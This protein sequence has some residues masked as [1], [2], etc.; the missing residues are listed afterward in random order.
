M[1]VISNS[2]SYRDFSSDSL[3][4]TLCL[5]AFH[6]KHEST[7]WKIQDF[8]V[9]QILREIKIGKSAILGHFGGSEF[10]LFIIFALFE[11]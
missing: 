9:T 4:Y 1:Y 3:A 5:F 6:Q 11:G 2:I 10:S 7:V 8:S